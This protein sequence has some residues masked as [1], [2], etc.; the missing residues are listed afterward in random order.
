MAYER[1]TTGVFSALCPRPGLRKPAAPSIMAAM[2]SNLDTIF[3]VV[4]GTAG[5]I[6]HGKSSVIERLTGVHPD[7]LPEEKA[8]GLTIDLGF[9]P[10]TLKSG[11][12]VG[13][14]DVPGHEKLVKNMVAGA[15][16]I[17]LVLLVVAADDGVMPQTREHLS[18]LQLLDAKHGLIALNKIDLVDEEFRELARA[19]VEESV[20]GTFLEGAP[21][22]EVSSVTGAGF[23]ELEAALHDAVE[24]VEPRDTSGIFRMPIQRVFSSKG[25]GTVVTGVPVSGQTSMGTTLEVVPLGQRG[26]VRGIHAYKESTDLA[27]A[28][29]S[30]AIN[31]TDVDYREIHRGMVLTEPGFFQGAEMFEANFRYTPMHSRPL[32]HRAPVRVHVGTAEVLGRVYLLQGKALEPGEES[33]VQFRLEE[34]LVAAPGDRFIVR[35]YSP[36]VTL[37]G[38][39][40]LDQSRWR[41]KAGKSFVIDQ[42]QRKAEAIGDRD[43]FVTTMLDSLGYDAATASDVAKRAGLSP[44]EV[45]EITASLIES[46]EVEQITRGNLLVASSRVSAARDELMRLTKAYHD[47]NPRRRYIEKLELKQKLASSDAFFQHVLERLKED[48]TVTELSGARLAFKGFGPQLSEEDSAILERLAVRLDEAAF[49]PPTPAEIAA[50]EGWEE[51]AASELAEL[52]IE[53]ERAIKLGP[54]LV[55]HADRIEKGRQLI[56]DHLT[57]NGTMTASEARSLFETTRK[58]CIP[59]LEHYDREK[60]T[61]RQGDVRKLRGE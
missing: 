8:R 9:A 54:A 42:L 6:D 59:L 56:R 20:A 3:N 14:I 28:G 41:L 37:G 13:I 24:N 46:G 23:E 35:A 47:A 49:C 58:F 7:R 29:H 16:G 40:I 22:I 11:Q 36:L 21:I 12:R 45:K 26:R 53:D 61:V 2:K 15:T 5:H 4:V 25:F 19:D 18:I 51:A 27:R 30:A 10:L 44:E 31:L 38:G 33:F 1:D 17:D 48:G 43:K 55:F 34:P 57:A 52:L 32:L 39:E 60:L 50:E